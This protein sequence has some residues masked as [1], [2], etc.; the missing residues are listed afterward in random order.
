MEAH[1]KDGILK[2]HLT[3]QLINSDV[4]TDRRTL[5]VRYA[6]DVQK[7]FPKWPKSYWLLG[8][9]YGNNFSGTKESKL[10]DQAIAFYKRAAEL[11]PGNQS[12]QEAVAA[13]IQAVEREREGYRKRGVL[14]L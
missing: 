5:A 3:R 9:I 12:Y 14:K 2:Y 7:M 6:W 10:A 4:V 8:I 13:N 11:A 1:P